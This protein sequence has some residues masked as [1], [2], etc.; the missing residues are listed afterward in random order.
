MSLDADHRVLEMTGENLQ[1]LGVEG[2][3]LQ[4]FHTAVSQRSESISR[5]LSKC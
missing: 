4:V 1:V 2:D 5:E 3:Q